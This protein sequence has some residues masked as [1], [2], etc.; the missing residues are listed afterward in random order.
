MLKYDLHVTHVPDHKAQVVLARIIVSSNSMVSMQQAVVMA[1][2]PPLLL[3]HNLER[4]V[5]EQHVEQL[6]SLGVEFDISEVQEALDDSGLNFGGHK[7]TSVSVTESAPPPPPPPDAQPEP[8]EQPATP[9][10]PAPLTHTPVHAAEHEFHHI[11]GGKLETLRKA[12][13]A[14]RKKNLI[15]AALAAAALLIIGL[16]VATP[17]KGGQTAEETTPVPADAKLEKKSARVKTKSGGN[18]GQTGYDTSA[19]YDGEP[20]VQATAQQK[21]QAGAYVDS[22][23]ANGADARKSV[24]FYKMAI[25]FNRQNLAAW[26]G[27]LQAYRELRMD[28]A[29]HETQSQMREIFGDGALSVVNIVKSHGELIDAYVNADGAY[30]VEYKIAKSSKVDILRDVFGMTR[31]VRAA[32]DCDNISIHASTGNGKGVA[33]HSTRHTSIHSLSEFMRQAEIVWQE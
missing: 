18:A 12:E 16:F 8:P 10:Q 20:R 22:A 31:A 7:E 23:K 32:C 13:N 11:P 14:S 9:E 26:Q 24:A 19:K 28:D 2:N 5:L 33:A 25:S 21:Q 17:P 27:L 29:A 1:A 4:K 3:F 30:I 6:N 15:F